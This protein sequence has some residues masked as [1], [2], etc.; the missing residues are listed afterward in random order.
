[1]CNSGQFVHT[2]VLC[3]QAVLVPA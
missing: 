1:M 3:H 2:H